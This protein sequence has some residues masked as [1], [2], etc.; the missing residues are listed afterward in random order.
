LKE[1]HGGQVT[2]FSVGPEEAQT[3]LKK[4]L[5]MGADEAVLIKDD[6]AELYDGWRIARIIAALLQQK[7]PEFDLLLFGKQSVGADNAQVPSMVAEL[8]GLPQVNV[9]TKLEL[10]GNKGVASREIEGAHEKVEFTLPAVISAQ[11][12]LNEPRYE[13]LRGIMAAKR[14]QIPVITLEELGLTPDEIKPR[15][16]IVKVESPPARKAGQVIEAEPPEAARKLVAFLHEE[17]K[18]I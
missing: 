14:K 16:E 15:L 13:T 4:C 11:K 2:V 12:G 8:L 7:Y 17:V 6:E 9:V 5:A 10:E 1:A 18:V 3:I